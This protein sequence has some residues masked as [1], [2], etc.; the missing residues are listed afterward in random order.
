MLSVVGSWICR[1][2]DGRNDDTFGIDEG[3]Q[4]K[5]EYE[6]G[7]GLGRHLKNE[8]MKVRRMAA[9]SERDRLCGMRPLRMRD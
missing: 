6:S 5:K 1:E 4:S 8:W 9:G 3:C 7:E 2:A